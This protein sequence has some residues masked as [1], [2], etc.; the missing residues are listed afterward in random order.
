[1]V[2]SNRDATWPHEPTDR[3][4]WCPRRGH[5]DT[6]SSGGAAESHRRTRA[7]Q[8]QSGRRGGCCP[9]RRCPRRGV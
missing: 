9:S 2:Q 5:C 7:V 6:E 3:K 1:M 4:D 8:E